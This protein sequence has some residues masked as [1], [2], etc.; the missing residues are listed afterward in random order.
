MENNVSGR[1]NRCYWPLWKVCDSWWRYSLSW[2]KILTRIWPAE[3]RVLKFSGF[4]SHFSISRI[5]EL[6]LS[7]MT[8]PVEFECMECVLGRWLLNGCLVESFRRFNGFRKRYVEGAKYS[9][10]AK[11]SK[12]FFMSGTASIVLFQRSTEVC[13]SVRRKSAEKFL[14]LKNFNVQLFSVISYK[15]TRTK[16][17]IIFQVANIFKVSFRWK[18][19]SCS[20]FFQS[21]VFVRNFCKVLR[22]EDSR[23]QRVSIER[24]FIS[25]NAFPFP[26]R[27]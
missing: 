14:T 22:V 20:E 16:H 10:S 13:Q 25:R 24:R 18:F 23:S 27:H 3:K 17:A 19:V 5:R 4:K 1:L 9:K 7:S 2:R 11:I 15:S 8:K 6:L 26:H 12:K 21:T